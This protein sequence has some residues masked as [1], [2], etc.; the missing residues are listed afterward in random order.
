MARSVDLEIIT[1][2]GA[3]DFDSV[4][5][6]QQDA[7]IYCR[8]F[9]IS[10]T[11]PVDLTPG[12]TRGTREYTGIKIE[13]RLDKASPKLLELFVA[14]AGLQAIFRIHKAD[15]SAR[16]APDEVAMKITIGA[17]D[18]KAWVSSYRLIVPDVEV[19]TKDGPDEPYEEVVFSFTHIEFHK[20]G[21]GYDGKP[22]EV[23]IQDSLTGGSR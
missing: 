4:M 17:P 8:R 15:T 7:H 10:S 6:G 5:D 13:K 20:S 1:K 12:A 14:G 2:E 11:S 18:F 3:I 23:V 21:T 22:H 16:Y 9:E 19:A